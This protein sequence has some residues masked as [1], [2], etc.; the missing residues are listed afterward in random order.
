MATTESTQRNNTGTN[1]TGISIPKR[2]YNNWIAA[3]CSVFRLFGGCCG[4]GPTS[5][6]KNVFQSC[7]FAGTVPVN[8]LT[9]AF[10]EIKTW[11]W[12]HL[13]VGETVGQVF[14]FESTWEHSEYL[15]EHLPL[16]P[17]ISKHGRRQPCDL[18]SWICLVCVCLYLL[19]TP[20]RTYKLRWRRR[21]RLRWRRRTSLCSPRHSNRPDRSRY[22]KGPSI[23]LHRCTLLTEGDSWEA[24][25]SES[26]SIIK[27]T[28]T[29]YYELYFYQISLLYLHLLAWE[30][31]PTP[32][33]VSTA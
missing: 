18:P 9:T 26:V 3:T 25:E 30:H 16:L 19:C 14:M 33:T 11:L 7:V 21:S 4:G 29:N 32:G 5:L 6:K 24:R 12:L 8:T 27:S 10:T 23:L 31:T 28:I 17:L 15:R 1:F 13:Q 2:D 20:E 22:S